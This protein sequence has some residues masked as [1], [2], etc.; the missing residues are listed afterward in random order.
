MLAIRGECKDLSAIVA[1]PFSDITA[2]RLGGGVHGWGDFLTMGAAVTDAQLEARMADMQP[3]NA[4]YLSY[5]SG[6]TGPPK[7]V[8][9]DSES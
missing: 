6:T 4:C 1:L 7:A 8:M 5:T 2:E 3:D 9:Y